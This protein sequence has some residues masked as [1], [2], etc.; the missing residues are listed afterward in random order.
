MSVEGLRENPGTPLDIAGRTPLTAYMIGNRLYVDARVI[1][2]EDGAVISIVK[3]K[4]KVD[5][6]NK[7]DFN[8]STNALEVVDSHGDPVFQMIRKHEGTVVVKGVVAIPAQG[9]Y[10]TMDDRGTTI[11]QLHKLDVQPIFA[12]PEWKYPGCYAR[13]G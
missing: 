5:G 3:D 13:Q 11:G 8:Y 2:P 12:Y 4:V 10:M 6:S 7:V 1:D 9:M